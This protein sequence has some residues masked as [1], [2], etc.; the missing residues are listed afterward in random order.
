MCLVMAVGDLEGH[1]GMLWPYFS[2]ETDQMQLVLLPGDD[3][4]LF[5][6][7][8]PFNDILDLFLCLLSP[9]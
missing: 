5:K 4:G 1:S 7:N 6:C 9:D 8:C 2:V 3:D